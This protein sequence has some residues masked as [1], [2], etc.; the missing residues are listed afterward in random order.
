M[1]ELREPQRVAST[2]GASP[3]FGA[4]DCL[5][6]VSMADATHDPG[7]AIGHSIEFFGPRRLRP[8]QSGDRNLGARPKRRSDAKA[9]GCR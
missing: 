6:L 8:I 5:L 9:P 7:A 2:G 1:G 3:I 4:P